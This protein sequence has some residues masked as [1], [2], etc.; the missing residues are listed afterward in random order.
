MY[1][2]PQCIPVTLEDGSL[3]NRYNNCRFVSNN[4]P[5]MQTG[6]NF[7]SLSFKTSV[8]YELR[9]K[10]TSTSV[11]NLLKKRKKIYDKIQQYMDKFSRNKKEEKKNIKIEF[12]SKNT[13]MKVSGI[14]FPD[15]LE[16]LI[17]N[18]AV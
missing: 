12:T 4:F 2:H 8:V 3:V 16:A 14:C 13:P 11:I 17:T 15:D 10:S 1:L 6:R 7:F 18:L 9:P 5:W